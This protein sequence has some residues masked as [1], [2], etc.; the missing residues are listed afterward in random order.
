MKGSVISLLALLAASAL[1]ADDAVNVGYCNRSG[2]AYGL[3]LSIMPTSDE[4][5][6]VSGVALGAI[7]SAARGVKGFQ[8]APFC[9]YAGRADGMQMSLVNVSEDAFNG[10]QLGLVNYA[11]GRGVQLGLVNY[12]EDAWMPFLPLV[13]AS[14]KGKAEREAAP[15]DDAEIKT[16]AKTKTTQL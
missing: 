8:G 12:I 9:C 2:K 16:D 4:N 6:K 10:F 11:D 1:V 7:S 5:I 3:K 14:F 13:N 15:K